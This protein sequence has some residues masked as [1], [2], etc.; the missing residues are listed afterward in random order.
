MIKHY[1]KTLHRLTHAEYYAYH[2]SVSERLAQK[3]QGLPRVKPQYDKYVVAF[4]GYDGSFKF[5]LEA[6]ETA[7]LVSLDGER[8]GAFFVIDH[9]IRDAAK[10][11]PVAEIKAAGEG[12]L[13]IVKNFAGTPQTDY[14]GEM[15]KVVNMVQDFEKPENVTRIAR[16]GQTEN[17]AALKQINLNFQALYETR[18]ESKYA[19][20]QSGNSLQWR[21]KLTDEFD[22]L[23]KILLGLRLSAVDPDEVQSLDESINVVNSTTDQFTTI[24]NRR[25]GVGSSKK[26]DEKK[27]E[28]TQAPDATNPPAPETPPQAPDATNPP[29]PETPNQNPVAVPPAINPDDLNPPA[30]GE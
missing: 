9:A 25:L 10:Y 11:S 5:M 7:Q 27:D 19:H 26:E 3:M 21:N 15:A 1:L 28:E 6:P 29:A 4:V 18:F 2:K 30:A 20:K 16:L 8:K 23:C 24:A 17:L 22:L 13:P 12:L 14:E